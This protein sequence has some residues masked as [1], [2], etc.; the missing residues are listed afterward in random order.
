MSSRPTSPARVGRVDAVGPHA[1]HGH[2]DDDDDEASLENRS[3][4]KVRRSVFAA[5]HGHDYVWIYPDLVP[6]G[7]SRHAAR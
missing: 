5:F 4:G 7:L 1:G 2:H 3:A 6:S